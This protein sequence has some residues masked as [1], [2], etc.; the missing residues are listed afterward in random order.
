MA[1]LGEHGQ[2]LTNLYAGRPRGDGLELAPD[3]LR[4]IG[5]HIEAIVLRQSAGQEDIDARLC[6]AA[7]LSGSDSRT[8]LA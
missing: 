2:M 5:F 8:G 6:L 4:S 1:P 7:R 3:V